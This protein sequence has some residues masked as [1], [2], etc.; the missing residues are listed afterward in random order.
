[1]LKTVNLFVLGW[2][3][4][5]NAQALEAGGGDEAGNG[6]DVVACKDGDYESVEILDFYEGRTILGLEPKLGPLND[7]LEAKVKLAI[8]RLAEIDPYRVELYTQRAEAFLKERR[9]LQD[10]R[11]PPIDDSN[12]NPVPRNCKVLQIARQL[13][14]TVANEPVYYIKEDLWRRLDANNKAGLILHEIIYR[15]ALA[16]GQRNSRVARKLTAALAADALDKINYPEVVRT[17]KMD[18]IEWTDHEQHS[19]WSLSHEK[20]LDASKAE[21]FCAARDL[22]LFRIDSMMPLRL[23]RLWSSW[24]ADYHIPFA[25]T[26]TVLA[27]DPETGGTIALVLSKNSY[28]LSD[29]TEALPALCFKQFIAE[30]YES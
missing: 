19:I 9:M 27:A 1:M 23:R 24:L 25:G 6:G 15:D 11:F 14:K 30:V 21:A 7:S 18:V 16:H 29:E 17:N 22:E 5:L 8:S 4:S 20:F 10:H 26:L 12:H 3:L 28:A 2:A 13:E